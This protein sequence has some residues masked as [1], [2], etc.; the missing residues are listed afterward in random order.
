MKND[1][2]RQHLEEVR[3]KAG[4]ITARSVVTYAS[5]PDSPLHGYFE[6]NDSV[7]AQKHREQQA[8][9]LIQRVTVVYEDQYGAEQPIRAYVVLRDDADGL[10]EYERVIDVMSDAE[11]RSRLL[12]QAKADLEAYVAKYE[13]LSELAG[14]M[15]SKA[16]ELAA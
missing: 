8:R 15:A 9:I 4:S 12:V 14:L 5:D 3:R 2:L 10:A 6:W 1:E 7:A 16:A 11:K 13:A